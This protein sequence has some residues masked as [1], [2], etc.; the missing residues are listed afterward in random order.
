MIK[1]LF[2]CIM[3]LGVLLL[4]GSLGAAMMLSTFDLV[5]LGFFLAFAA[6]TGVAFCGV[7][8]ILYIAWGQAEER[9]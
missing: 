7:G 8:L 9:D 3:I 4:G 5:S 2:L 6:L 1:R